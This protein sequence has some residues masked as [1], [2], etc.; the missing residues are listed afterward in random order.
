ML[1]NYLTDERD[2]KPLVVGLKI[3]RQIYQ[4]SPFK[5]H[6]RK[7]V[8]PGPACVTDN[9]FEQYIR[10]QSQTMYHPVGTCRM[11]P[12]E[13]GVVDHR[14]RVKG[15]AGL[16]IVDASVMPQVPSGNTSAP[17]IMIA[18]RASRMILE[19]L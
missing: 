5:E 17:V 15:L 13:N 3:I 9:D 16:R 11:G 7:E 10:E 12:D 1:A 19:D 6:L 8:L 18:E 4:T 2:I 14:L